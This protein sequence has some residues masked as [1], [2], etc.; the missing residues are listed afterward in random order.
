[1]QKK[2]KPGERF[3]AFQAKKKEYEKKHRKAMPTFGAIGAGQSKGLNAGVSAGNMGLVAPKAMKAPKI[4]RMK[5]KVEK[6]RKRKEH[7]EESIKALREF[8]DDESKEKGRKAKH[9]KEHS[10]EEIS[11]LRKFVDEE[12]KEKGKKAKRKSLRSPKEVVK[13]EQNASHQFKKKHKK[14][15][16]SG[17]IGKPGALHRE[18]GVK[19]GNKIPAKS[20]AKAA[21]KGGLEGKRARLA[22]TL[23]GFH[24][25]HEKKCK[26]CG[27]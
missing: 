19:A 20:L 25:K 6:K 7:S 9:R 11:G 1:M 14:N 4:R 23:K 16:I 27:K 2:F 21:K 8:A 13:S 26:V 22:E 17:A 18:M 15:W 5:R 12:A 24:H 10:S 3:N